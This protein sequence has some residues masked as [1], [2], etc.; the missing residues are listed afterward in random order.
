M[1]EE[2]KDIQT[3]D[4]NELFSGTGITFTEVTQEELS[5]M[6]SSSRK[7]KEISES[8]EE[9]IKEEFL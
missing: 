2:N 6:Q 5:Q 9:I 1:S 3:F 4:I 7:M 8:G